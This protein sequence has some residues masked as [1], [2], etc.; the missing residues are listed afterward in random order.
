[1]L[2]LVN[3]DAGRAIVDTVVY[4]RRGVVEVPELRGLAVP[5]GSAVRLD[6]ARIIP[7]RD[8]LT[9]RV[10]TN[11][12]RVSASLSDTV[13]ELGAGVQATDWLPS[14]AGPTTSNLLLGLPRGPGRRTL[15]IANPGDAETRATVRI[16][17]EDAV[18][19]PAG[20]EDVVVGPEATRRLSLTSVLQGADTADA[21]GLLVESTVPVTTTLRSFVDGDLS[22]AVPAQ[23]LTEATTVIAA[24]GEKR[25]LL[26]GADRAGVVTVR[27]TSAEGVQVTEERV[28]VAPGR[29]YLVPLPPQAALVTVTPRSAEIAGSV[30]S[31]TD[32][33]RAV[34]RL[35]ALQRTSLVPDV[36]PGLP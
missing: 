22:H 12:G 15:L 31:R 25:L 26:G 13:D 2:E 36:R 34:V 6:L 8:N 4:G 23:P 19:S 5:G 30:L 33:G 1:V 20:A 11:R 28:E 21:I 24:P 32:D 35:R 16:V 7:R 29:G 9:L 14:Q 18:F 17:T 3:P 27:A 10:S